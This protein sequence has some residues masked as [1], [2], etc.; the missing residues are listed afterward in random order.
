MPMIF[1]FDACACK[2][3]DERSGVAK[4]CRTEPTTLPPFWTIKA[5]AS[6]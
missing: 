4:G 1:A 5:E 3:N 2:M 6:R